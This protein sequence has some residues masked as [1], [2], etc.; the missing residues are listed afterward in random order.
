MERKR[1][2]IEQPQIAV[3][4]ETTAFSI[5]GW[6]SKDGLSAVNA[7]KPQSARIN[8]IAGKI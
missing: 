5:L 4:V 7:S 3:F 1:I 6:A 2:G 8:S